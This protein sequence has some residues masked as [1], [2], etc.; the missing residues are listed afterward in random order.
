[1]QICY[2]PATTVSANINPVGWISDLGDVIEKSVNTAVSNAID[3]VIVKPFQGWC[4]GVWCGFIDVSLPA[5]TV[6]SLTSLM[7]YMLGVKKARQ[8]II[9]PIIV[10]LFLRV[11]DGMITGGVR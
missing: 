7:L 9:I 11:A 8:W 3:T 4:Y 2:I 6:I 5:C 10:Y 1:M